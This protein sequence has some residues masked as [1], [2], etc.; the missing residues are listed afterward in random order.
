VTTL[1]ECPLTPRQLQMYLVLC[2]MIHRGERL[3]YRTFMDRT[4]IKSPNGVGYVLERLEKKGMIARRAVPVQKVFDRKKVEY[5]PLAAVVPLY[6][7]ELYA[8]ECFQRCPSG[9]HPTAT[10]STPS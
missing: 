10:T 6:R 1:E 9:T 7:V 5:C 3:T 8:P 2:E 4:G